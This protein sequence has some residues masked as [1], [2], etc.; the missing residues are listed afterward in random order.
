MTRVEAIKIVEEVD[1]AAG[2]TQAATAGWGR[3]KRDSSGSEAK[4]VTGVCR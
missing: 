3:W 2:I 4:A 1:A